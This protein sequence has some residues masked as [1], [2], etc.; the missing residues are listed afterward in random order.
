MNSQRFA[1][2]A[3][4]A[5]AGDKSSLEQLL[6]L[7]PFEDIWAPVALVFLGVGIVVGVGGSLTAIRKFLRV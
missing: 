7:V 5:Q 3:S 6:R 2:L 4:Q 1:Q